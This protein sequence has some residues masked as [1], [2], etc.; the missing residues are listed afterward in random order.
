MKKT[1]ILLATIATILSSC[2]KESSNEGKDYELKIVLTGATNARYTIEVKDTQSGREYLNRTGLSGVN[3][4]VVQY[5][6]TSQQSMNV[7]YNTVGN[8]N[9]KLY[10]NDVQFYDENRQTGSGGIAP[11]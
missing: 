2:K 3:T 8:L 1:F 5:K 4:F 11:Y 9:I 10:K 6:T 7:I